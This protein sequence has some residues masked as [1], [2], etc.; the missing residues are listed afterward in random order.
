KT[1]NVR[2]N[3]GSADFGSGGHNL[4]GAGDGTVTWSLST[5]NGSLAV[6]ARVRGTLY[7]DA[8][9]AGC[10]GLDIGFM[11]ESSQPA[12]GNSHRTAKICGPGGDANDS[13]NQVAVDETF[14]SPDLAAVVISTCESTRVGCFGSGRS[15]W[16]ATLQYGDNAIKV[17]APVDLHKY[18]VNINNGSTDFGRGP[19]ALGGP[20]GSG[21]VTLKYDSTGKVTGIVSG[22]V[23]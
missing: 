2:L 21:T 16:F 7:W 4:G 5:V 10:A 6:G 1:D 20:G 18:D 11:N 8:T 9:Q 23:Y 17:A 13:H 22:T 12:A 15:L 14:A 3:G 19:H